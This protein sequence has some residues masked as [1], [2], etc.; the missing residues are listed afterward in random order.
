MLIA[1][2]AG[3]RVLDHDGFEHSHQSRSTIAVT[4]ALEAD[5]QAAVQASLVP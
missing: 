1:R 2:E 5:V 4:P 3:D